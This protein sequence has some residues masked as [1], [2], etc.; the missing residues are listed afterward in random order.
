MY[1]GKWIHSWPVYRQLTGPDPLGRGKAAASPADRQPSAPRTGERG[2]GRSA[3]SARTAR[4]A[5]RSACTSQDGRSSRSRATRTARS[6][7]AGCARRDRR[8][9][10]SSPGR[11]GSSKVRYRPPYATEWQELDLDTA[12]DMVA[13][14]VLDARRKGWQDARRA[15]ATSCAAPWASP[16]SAARRWTTRRTT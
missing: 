14:R 13:D 8:A 12:M 7:A 6:P 2:P 1:I 16:A 11:S 5:A 9:S 10:S 4:S 15:R 3:R